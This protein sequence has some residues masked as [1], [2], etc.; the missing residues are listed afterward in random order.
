MTGY[1]GPRQA[2]GVT[3]LVNPLGAG[4]WVVPFTPAVFG[5]QVPFEVYHA[6]VSG[7]SSSNFQVFIDST[8]YDYAVRGDINSWD[9]AQP[10]VIQ[11]GNTLYYYWNTGAAPMPS[12]TVFCRETS[13]F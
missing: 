11:P 10:M 9:P 3:N 12:V 6:T 13:A 7:P 4:F 5:I 2:R 1:L 8:F